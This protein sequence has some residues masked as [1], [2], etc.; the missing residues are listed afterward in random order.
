MPG[1]GHT[2]LTREKGV[3]FLFMYT[4][5]MPSPGAV[6]YYIEDG[7]YHVFNRGNNKQLVFLDD[8]DYQVFLGYFWELIRCPYP[9]LP[10]TR[11]D[12][13]PLTYC[14]MG[15]HLHFQFKQITVDGITNLMKRL[16]IKYVRY[17]NQRH[18]RFGR[19]FQSAFK[20]KHIT[21]ET[22]LLYLSRYIHLNPAEI[23]KQPL[24]NYPYSSYGQYLNQAKHKNNLL[25][26][27][28]ILSFFKSAQNLSLKDQSSYQHF[29]ESYQENSEIILEKTLN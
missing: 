8:Q 27:E 25:N 14:L 9:E 22:Y 28:E 1:E 13:I 23:W 3:T 29:V 7:Y 10:N 19:L 17:F 24:Y 15:T 6:K 4:G 20:A 21:D 18:K 26:T 2:F 16:T 12:I 5:D 11:Q